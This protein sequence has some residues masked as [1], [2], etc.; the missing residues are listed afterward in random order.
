MLWVS[1]QWN[2]LLGGSPDRTRSQELGLRHALS[3]QTVP[4]FEHRL[5][6]AAWLLIKGHTNHCCDAAEALLGT[7]PDID[8]SLA[9]RRGTRHLPAL[10]EAYRTNGD[11]E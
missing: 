2:R 1:R 8:Q 3:G 4:A 7:I 11:H 10:R 6:D 5:I 9:L